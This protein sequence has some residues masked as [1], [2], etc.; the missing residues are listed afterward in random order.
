MQIEKNC[1]VQFHYSMWEGKGEILE[2]SRN[3]EPVTYLHGHG[4]IF[5]GVEESLQGKQKG[6]RVEVVL[7]PEQTFGIPRLDAQ[8]RVSKKYLKQAGKYKVGDAV[9]LQT[10]NGVK[11]VTVVK[12][13][14]STV[15]IDTNHPFAGKV[16]HF[17]IEV[18]E[19]REATAEEIS[20]GH[21]HG[22]GGHHH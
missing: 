4:G 11:L 15:D 21:V 9:P 19:I 8:Q 17:D 1:V 5:E 3:A 13:G 10:E 16:L 22:P 20:H 7:P 14:H 18:I 12:V 2:T 6:D